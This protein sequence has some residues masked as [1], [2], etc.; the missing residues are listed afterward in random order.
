MERL[1]VED[2]ANAFKV[3]ERTVKRLAWDGELP[4]VRV[5][6]GAMRFEPEAV[7]AFITS[8]RRHMPPREQDPAWRP[9]LATTHADRGGARGAG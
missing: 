5:A 9:G 1:T 8:K 7:E 6:R 4:F 2:V 3:P